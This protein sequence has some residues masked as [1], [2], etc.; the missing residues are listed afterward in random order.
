MTLTQ[1]AHIHTHKKGEQGHT[2]HKCI[3]KVQSVYV[4]TPTHKDS[5]SGFNGLGQKGEGE[6]RERDY[7]EKG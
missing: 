7:K 4:Y 6:G 3:K 1:S 5:N 2:S